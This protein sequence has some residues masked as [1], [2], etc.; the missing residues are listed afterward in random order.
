MIVLPFLFVARYVFN[1]FFVNKLFIHY[2][3][4]NA[5]APRKDSI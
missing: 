3:C 4:A 5:D 1:R 2:T